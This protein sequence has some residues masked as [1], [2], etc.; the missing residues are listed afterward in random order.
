MISWKLECPISSLVRVLFLLVCSEPVPP[1]VYSVASD[2]LALIRQL[3]TV[4]R[5][6]LV[7]IVSMVA[8]VFTNITLIL[9]GLFP[10][11]M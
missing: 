10:G 3:V 6:M 2:S 4:R 9:A 7:E 11:E 8:S 5:K 1:F